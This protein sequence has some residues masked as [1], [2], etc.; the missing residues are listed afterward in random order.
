M[1][2]IFRS[3]ARRTIELSIPTK[4]SGQQK[5]IFENPKIEKLNHNI[6]F[7]Q[8]VLAAKGVNLAGVSGDSM[9]AHY[10]L[11][12]GAPTGSTISRSPRPQEHLD[13]GTHRQGEETD[14]HGHGPHGGRARLRGRGCRCGL[15]TRRS[16][17]R[18]SR[19]ADFR[20]LYDR[21][22][23]PLVSVLADLELTGIRVDVPF[24]NKLGGRWG[25]NRGTRK[26]HPRA[27]AGRDF[28]IGSLPQLQKVLFEDLK[29]PVQKRTGIKNEPSTDQESLEHS[30]PSATR[31]RRS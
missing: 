5:P 23:I 9:L 6:K 7:D 25:P 29:L 12:P 27:L 17:S 3:V 2:T 10:L 11:E 8:I 22:E 26:S 15:A 21:L 16:S 18:D 28:K 24:L 19:S 30:P 31:C 13:R 20:A 14:D 1:P 4:R